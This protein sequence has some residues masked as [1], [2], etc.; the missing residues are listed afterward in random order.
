MWPQNNVSAI[1]IPRD[2][3]VRHAKLAAFAFNSITA[4]V[5]GVKPG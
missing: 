5:K 4:R 1:K 2:L 3:R